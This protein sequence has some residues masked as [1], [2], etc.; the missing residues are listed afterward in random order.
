[1]QLLNQEITQEQYE[2]EMFDIKFRAIDRKLELAQKYNQDETSLMASEMDLQIEVMQL[3]Q[4]KIEAIEKENDEK[5]KEQDDE[6]K[7]QQEEL[8]KLMMEA[9]KV[10]DSLRTP[11]EVRADDMAKEL[12]RLEELHD[13]GVLLEE[14]YEKK[15]QAVH[16]KYKQ[17]Q[18]DEDLG[19]LKGYFEKANKVMEGVS[20][21]TSALQSAETAKLE[22]EYQAISHV[23]FED[24]DGDGRI[25]R[26]ETVN[27]MYEVTNKGHR[28]YSDVILKVDVEDDARKFALSPSTTTTIAPGQTVR[29]KAKAFCKSRTSSGN[30]TFRVSANSMNGGNASANLQIR[31]SKK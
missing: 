23:T 29:Y 14:D 7:R 4:K 3:A 30:V 15:V 12:A 10:K 16:D 9:E 26:N 25:S 24:E 11:D 27:I 19:R 20:E 13:A 21:F 8:E 5:L 28:T 1:M 6:I 17:E 31:M 22:S 18:L 2:S